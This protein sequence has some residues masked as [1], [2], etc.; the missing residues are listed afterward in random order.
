MFSSFL[1]YFSVEQ[2]P[3]CTEFIEWCVNN[4]SLFEGVIM[5]ASRSRMLCPIDS[6]NIRNTLLIP[7]EFTQMSS[8]YNEGDILQFFQRS[9]D[10][11]KDAILR[12]CLNP[13]NQLSNPFFPID[14]DMFNE[15]NQHI[16]TLARMG[17]GMDLNQF[18]T[19]PL[20]SLIFTLISGKIVSEALSETSPSTYL[21]FYEFLAKNIHSQLSNF[22]QSRTFRFQSFLLKMYLNYNEKN[23]QVLDMVIIEDMCKYYCKFMNFLMAPVHEVLF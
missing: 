17:L 11:K 12:A 6:L 3:S 20:L 10:E 4:Y 19:E 8:E 22:C 21:Q 1:F 9:S 16:I 13:E 7:S 2:T 14:F 15:E 23:L 18:I 5:D